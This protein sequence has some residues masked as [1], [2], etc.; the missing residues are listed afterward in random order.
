[1]VC[2]QH[3]KYLPPCSSTPPLTLGQQPGFPPACLPDTSA[4]RWSMEHRT[5]Q[6][7]GGEDIGSP[8]F[9]AARQW[10]SCSLVVRPGCQASQLLGLLTA[11]QLIGL[12]C[13]AVD[14]AADLYTDHARELADAGLFLEALWSQFEDVS[15]VHQPE[16]EILSLKQRGRPVAE[17]IRDFRWVAGRLH[18]WPEHLLIHQFLAGL[19]WDLCQ[20]Y[21]FWGVPSRVQ[22]WFRVV[23]DLDAELR[24]FWNKGEDMA[25]P[26]RSVEKL[27][28]EG[29]RTP[30]PDTG[31]SGPPSW[32][33]FRFFRC[34][35]SGQRAAECPFPF[36]GDSHR[37][38]GRVDP[39]LHPRRDWR[40]Q[41][42]L[43]K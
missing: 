11:E 21:V 33:S 41:G 25:V 19:D 10:I 26:R 12:Q 32:P 15:L 22:E 7:F 17:Y 39:H 35:Q 34:E 36:H 14:W 27:R 43:S 23:V 31:S 28:N 37:P 13:E 20:V 1:M 42:Q 3:V 24:V 16:A 40:G 2:S 29:R 5:D 9:P 4:W 38:Q 8:G 30:V 18:S 6:L